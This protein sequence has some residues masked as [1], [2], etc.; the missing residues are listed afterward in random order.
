MLQGVPGKQKINYIDESGEGTAIATNC[1]SAHN[2]R[3]KNKSFQSLMLLLSTFAVK[4]PCLISSF[5]QLLGPNSVPVKP[6]LLSVTYKDYTKHSCSTSV[7]FKLFSDTISEDR[8]LYFV[9]YK[10]IRVTQIQRNADGLPAHPF[11]LLKQLR[12]L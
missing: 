12:N 3:H 8:I 4:K 10:S 7:I 9:T 2:K 1:S 6:A 11:L 5:S